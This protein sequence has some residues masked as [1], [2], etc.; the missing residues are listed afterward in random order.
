VGETD[1]FLISRYRF[2]L[3][4]SYRDCGQHQRALDN[5]LIRADLGYWPEEVFVSLYFAAKL[6][7]E[8]GFPEDEVL[9]TFKRATDAV[10]S[11][12]EGLHGSARYCRSK[13]RNEEGFQFARRGAEIAKPPSGLF[14]EDWIYD[15]GLLDELAAR[16]CQKASASGSPK[17]PST[18]WANCPGRRP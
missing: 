12:A 1:P 2:Y 11:R 18:R 3:A 5:Y 10:P 9:S 13:G 8:L 15:Y 16:R 7:D 4:Q 14:V 6:Q 17:T